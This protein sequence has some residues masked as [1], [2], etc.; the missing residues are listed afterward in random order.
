MKTV[1]QLE[2]DVQMLIGL[3][4]NLESKVVSLESQSND[5]ASNFLDRPFGVRSIVAGDG[6]DVETVGSTAVIHTDAG[7]QLASMSFYTYPPVG[8]S[9]VYNGGTV[10]IHGLKTINIAGGTLTLSGDPCWAVIQHQWGTS[11][12]SVVCIAG[13]AVPTS[14]GTHMN[15]PL[16]RFFVNSGSDYA[17]ENGDLRWVGDPSPLAPLQ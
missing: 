16:S 15:W 12:A 14:N 6:I 3:I 10:N 2:S 13:S 1:E 8:S 9:V 17:R 7:N 4:A 5:P 11:T